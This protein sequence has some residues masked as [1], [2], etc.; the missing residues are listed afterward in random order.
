MNLDHIRYGD[1]TVSG[2]LSCE[3]YDTMGVGKMARGERNNGECL[4][5]ASF[6]I[7]VK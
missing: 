2:L 5:C 7:I 1:S 4:S 6:W 3:K